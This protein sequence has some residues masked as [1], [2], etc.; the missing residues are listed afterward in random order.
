MSRN[1][2]C[3][4]L[5]VADPD[6]RSFSRFGAVI[7]QVAVCPE[8]VLAKD[9]L[10]CCPEHSSK[11]VDGGCLFCLRASR[12][13]SEF[14]RALLWFCQ[15]CGRAV[16][17]RSHVCRV[18]YDWCERRPFCASCILTTIF[19]PRQALDKHRKMLRD[20]GVLCRR[21]TCPCRWSR[22][23]CSG[24]YVARAA[25]APQHPALLVVLLDPRSHRCAQPQQ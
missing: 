8:P 13:L 4:F 19:L 9:R 6:S 17:D 1:R 14:Y 22:A 2:F 23:D 11:T 12:V 24:V 5:H 15:R 10:L 3:D 7:M 16:A 21:S 25:Y 20:K 18:N